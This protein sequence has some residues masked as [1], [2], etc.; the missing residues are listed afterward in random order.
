ML[1]P[2]SVG[3]CEGSVSFCVYVSSCFVKSRGRI[4]VGGS[5][6]PIGT[7]DLENY[8]RNAS[9]LL[10]ATECTRRSSAAGDLKREWEDVFSFLSTT[11]R[12][13]DQR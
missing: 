6:E 5:S 10:K 9:A 11:K 7:E 3:K 12:T 1:L 13:R 8:A 4:G 2:S